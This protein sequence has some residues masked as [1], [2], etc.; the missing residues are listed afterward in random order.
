MKHEL[1]DARGLGSLPVIGDWQ[2]WWGVWG[3][4]IAKAHGR[5]GWILLLLD[6]NEKIQEV[7]MLL[8]RVLRNKPEY[9][10]TGWSQAEWLNVEDQTAEAL[11]WFERNVESPMKDAPEWAHFLF[12][13]FYGSLTVLKRLGRE[14]RAVQ[15]QGYLVATLERCPGEGVALGG[16]AKEIV[17]READ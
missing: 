17:L 11:A 3:P 1:R 14:L 5:Q 7:E 8:S 9:D 2:E 13:S 15:E 4:E 12:S 6:A 16:D 10:T